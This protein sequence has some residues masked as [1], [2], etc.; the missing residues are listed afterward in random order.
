MYTTRSLTLVLYSQQLQGLK[1][2]F[3][4]HGICTAVYTTIL[5]L[6]IQSGVQSIL[7]PWL[8]TCN[9]QF[10]RRYRLCSKRFWI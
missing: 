8:W 7:R 2:R 3:S 4:G 10:S 5:V 9:V 1:N 6:D